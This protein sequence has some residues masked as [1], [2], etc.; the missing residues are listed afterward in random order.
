MPTF[1]YFR[2]DWPTFELACALKRKTRI[3][4]HERVGCW[5]PTTCRQLSRSLP[6]KSSSQP[7]LVCFFLRWIAIINSYSSESVENLV[8][9]F[10]LLWLH[11]K[12]AWMLKRGPPHRRLPKVQQLPSNTG[13]WFNSNVNQV[14]T[15]E[16]ADQQL[17][18]L[19]CPHQIHL[20]IL[21]ILR[22]RHGC[23]RLSHYL[24][25]TLIQWQ[26]SRGG[27]ESGQK[28][29]RRLPK[30][31]L[32]R[33]MEGIWKSRA[34]PR[35]A[36]SWQNGCSGTYNIP[37]LLKSSSLFFTLL[38][39]LLAYVLTCHLLIVRLSFSVIRCVSRRNL[40]DRVVLASKFSPPEKAP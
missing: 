14:V 16:G 5:C 19:M 10:V 24:R 37:S 38:V 39:Q 26:N 7:L 31:W 21:R 28:K 11:R 22:R 36:V 33:S 12:T 2:P 20:S 9:R 27:K 23:I 18:L 25:W 1:S 34:E 13:V 32:M 35:C 15:V 4:T 17:W 8:D 6:Y 29:R 3:H 40:P 30:N